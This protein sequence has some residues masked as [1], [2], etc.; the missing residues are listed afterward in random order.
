MLDKKTFFPEFNYTTDTPPIT[1]EIKEETKNLLRHLNIPEEEWNFVMG[2][3]MEKVPEKYARI[4]EN[5]EKRG[6]K[7]EYLNDPATDK[8][9]FLK[10][11]G[12][13]SLFKDEEDTLIKKHIK[14][15][16]GGIYIRFPQ[17]LKIQDEFLYLPSLLK[18][19]YVPFP[20]T[21]IEFQENSKG[22]IALGS[23]APRLINSPYYLSTVEI[24]IKD[25]AKANISLIHSFPSYLDARIFTRIFLGKGANLTLSL[26]NFKNG[27]I[28]GRDVKAVLSKESTLNLNTLSFGV[29]NGRYYEWIEIEHRGE[30]SS[31]LVNTRQVSMDTSSSN[32][33]VKIKAVAGSKGAKAHIDS[34]GVV[35]S[36]DA[37]QFSLPAFE[38]SEN[39]VQMSH[40]AYIGQI[41]EKVAI[42]LASRGLTDRDIVY[43]MVKSYLEEVLSFTL[44]ER[45]YEVM[46]KFLEYL[47]NTR[48]IEI[49]QRR[50]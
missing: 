39:L 37:E 7:I 44:P 34:K 4:Q 35:L 31:S 50:T 24:I 15:S 42:Y 5:L 49:I 33:F 40:S 25:G 1:P 30:N 10:K 28:T 26:L 11:A 2:L 32:S 14:K 45:F 43:L 12:V 38:T 23:P 27:K 16:Y 13:F 19:S 20:H 36:H 21:Y 9:L 41:E 22:N 8:K 6:L 47:L 3:E 17:N 48:N 29:E 46:L 18:F